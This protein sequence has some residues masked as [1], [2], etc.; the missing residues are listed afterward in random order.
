MMK[1]N[2]NI[3]IGYIAICIYACLSGISFAWTKR[4]LVAGLPVFTL[5]LIRLII[6]AFFLLIV[7]KLCGKLERLKRKDLLWFICLAMGEPVIYFIGEDFGMKYVD[8]SFASV[9]I[10]MIPVLVAFAIPLVFGGKIKK[11]LVVGAGISLVGIVVMSFNK[12][13]FTFDVRG[14][15]F[16]LLALSAAIWF[17]V[18]LQKLL[19]TYGAF[20]V[21]A[22]INLIG[23]IAYIPLFFIFDYSQIDKVHWT[24]QMIGDLMCLGVFCSAGSYGFYSFAAKKLSVEKVSVFNNVA[25]IITILA[26]V[27]M[28]MEL[29]TIR[30]TLGILIVVLG[31]I[32][33]QGLL[34]KRKTSFE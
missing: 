12:N 19:K 33:S 2:K 24:G 28:G 22:Y 29:F 14:L 20:S 11:S 30:K 26:A 18:F 34:K 1:Q 25:P 16:L 3:L 10:A 32:I 21:T 17:N 27:L 7:L 5:V 31:V 15:L 9:I 13:G 6:G 23:A 4:L 8:A